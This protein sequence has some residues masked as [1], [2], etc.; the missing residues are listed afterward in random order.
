M[1]Q[2]FNKPYPSMECNCMKKD[3][4][5][6]IKYLKTKNPYGYDETSTKI[7]KISSPFVSSPLNYI[8]NKI[9]FWGV[10]PYRIKYA[11][12]KPQHKN[13][14]RCDVSNSRP[15]SLFNI[16]LKNIWNHNVDKDFK[17][18]HQIQCIKQ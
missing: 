1:E 5:Q 18:R 7:L 3:N 17:T 4:D 13:D 11:V 12:I 14:D 8:C 9:I 10:F 16:I 2:V 15:V 6:I